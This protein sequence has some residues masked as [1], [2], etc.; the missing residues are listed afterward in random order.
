M[1]LNREIITSDKAPAAVGPYSQAV[2]VGD[3]IYTAGQIPL[4]PETGKI[5]DG[6]IEAQTR[7]VLQNLSHVL[8][9][10]GSSLTHIVKTT[11]F[12]TDLADFS[13]INKVYGEFFV[14]DPP[15]RSTVQ[16][17]AL[18]LGAQIEIEA[19]AVQKP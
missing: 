18:P 14:A 16:V 2:R 12:V 10:A 17:A 5:I 19:V 13:T 4:V 8:D 1:S 3:F 15:A 9:S 7:Q 6:D 11:I